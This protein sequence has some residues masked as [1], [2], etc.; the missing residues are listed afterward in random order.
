[1]LH[2]SQLPYQLLHYRCL[3]DVQTVDLENAPF[4]NIHIHAAKMLSYGAH[5]IYFQK[6]NVDTKFTNA[7]LLLSCQVVYFIGHYRQLPSP[8]FCA[9]FRNIRGRVGYFI[10]TF[11]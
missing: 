5:H 3:T 10:M 7:L 4:I 8:F 1:M 9:R 2:I 11:T 6:M